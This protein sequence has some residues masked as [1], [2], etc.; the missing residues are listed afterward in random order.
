MKQ[1][2]LKVAAITT[3]ILAVICIIAAVVLVQLKNTNETDT[4]FRSSYEIKLPPLSLTTAED[5][6]DIS[7]QNKIWSEIEAYKDSNDYT[8]RNA[9]VIENPFQTNSQSIYIYFKTEEPASM[10]YT[11]HTENTDIPDFT[12]T[13]FNSGENNM[14]TEHEYQLLG[15]VPDTNNKIILTLTYSSGKTETTSFTYSAPALLGSGKLILTHKDGESSEALEDGLYTVFA[16]DS[17]FYYYDNDGILRSEFPILN[18]RAL[19]LIFKD[20]KMYYSAGVSTFIEMNSLG[21]LTNI[22]D[23]GTY[24]VHHDYTFDDSGN[25]LILATDTQ[26]PQ[27][28]DR[29][30]YLKPDTGEI[31]QVLDLTDI[32]PDYYTNCKPDKEGKLDWMHI[33]T[34]Q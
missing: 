13:C 19:R 2:Y 24:N 4:V 14:T 34:I 27:E 15:V 7:A 22:Y 29:I 30:L 8:F 12:R 28:E 9:L 10:K 6:Y 21:R 17:F 1:Q 20:D 5:I 26:S 18:Y 33:N 11:I 16:G 25:I 23:L 3:A 32:F 31:S